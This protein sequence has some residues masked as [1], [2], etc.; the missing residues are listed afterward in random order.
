MSEIVAR[1]F[2]L[3]GRVLMTCHGSLPIQPPSGIVKNSLYLIRNFV[4]LYSTMPDNHCLTRLYCIVLRSVC[5]ISCVI[6]NKS[7]GVQSRQPF[8]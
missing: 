6:Y 5:K 2:A 7:T 8:S 4:L 1:L 3:L